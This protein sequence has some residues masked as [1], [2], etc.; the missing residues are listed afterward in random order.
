MLKVQVTGDSALITAVLKITWITFEVL[1]T[2]SWGDL[3][4]ELLDNIGQLLLQ[5]WRHIDIIRLQLDTKN[6]TDNQ[7]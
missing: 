1:A 3:D 5:I 6:T 2:H 4:S 7:H